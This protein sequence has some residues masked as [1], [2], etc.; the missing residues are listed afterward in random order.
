MSIVTKTSPLH[1]PYLILIY[2]NLIHQDID[3]SMYLNL[4]LNLIV[5]YKENTFP[6]L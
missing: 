6:I 2:K 1:F 5:R 4:R 3:I